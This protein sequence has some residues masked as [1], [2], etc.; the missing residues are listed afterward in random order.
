M[1]RAFAS[2]FRF[3]SAFARSIL[4]T[5]GKV[6]GQT[7]PLKRCARRLDPTSNSTN[8]HHTRSLAVYPSWN[9]DTP[10]STT[11]SAGQSKDM[12]RTRVHFSRMI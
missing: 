12:A 4:P 10:L 3:T 5:V 6:L 7:S 11:L 2:R 1:A 8:E 9:M